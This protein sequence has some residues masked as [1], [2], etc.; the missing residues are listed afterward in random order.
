MRPIVRPAEA[1]DV[2]A[3][4]A[5]RALL[6]PRWRESFAGAAGG[7]LL[8]STV[9][10]Y[11]AHVANGCVMVTEVA[12]AVNAYSVVLPDAVL[13]TT[14]VYAK[15]H[16]AGLAPGLLERLEGAKVAYFDQLAARPGHGAAATRLAFLHLIETCAVHDAVLATTVI[17]PVVN[18]AAV[19]LLEAVGFRPVGSIEE[20]YP[21]VGAV[22]S[23][24]YLVE[25]CSV[26]AAVATAR[27]ERFKLRAARS[28][29]P[30]V[31]S[32]A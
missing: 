15:R 21:E 7:F 28:S 16:D 27:G 17:E 8:G 29:G 30:V 32:S 12:G 25:T 22:T 31:P 20:Q 6:T 1:G 4:M 26:V 18:R 24:V 9:D 14:E 2:E 13:R 19:P 23:R 10:A 5:I 11:H 3:L